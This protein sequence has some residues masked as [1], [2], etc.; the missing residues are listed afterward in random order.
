MAQSNGNHYGGKAGRDRDRGSRGP[1][2]YF[3]DC[4][5]FLEMR[6][7]D[8]P[9]DQRVDEGLAENELD[10]RS[11]FEVAAGKPFDCQDAEAGIVGFLQGF[12]QRSFSLAER[13]HYNVERPRRFGDSGSRS[14]RDANGSY[15][16]ALL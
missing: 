4:H 2:A 16:A 9:H 15:L 13:G 7:I 1:E 8:R 5:R 10:R 6:G 3:S 14:R 11:R 12:S